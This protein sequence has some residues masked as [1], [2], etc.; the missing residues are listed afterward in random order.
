MKTMPSS[1]LATAGGF[2]AILLW[3]TT[4]AVSRSLSEQVGPVTAAAAVCSVGGVAAVASLLRCSRRRRQIL[5]LP[6]RYLVGCGA[7]FVGYMLLLYLA[8]GWARSRQ[9][10]LEVGLLNYLWP[11]WTL[12]LSLVLLGKK[13]NW[14]LFPGTLLALAGIFLVVTQ[15]E[16]VS[17][18]SFARHFASNPGAYSLAIAAAAAWA[19]Y[20]S[21]TSKWAG[22]QKEGG[23]AFFLPITAMVLFLICCFLDEPCEWNRRAIAESLFMGFATY[24]AYAL[25]DNAMRRGSVVMVV[26]ASYLTPL[27]S[28]IASCLYLA[29]MP[30]TRLWAGCAI[31]IF[32]SVLSWQSISNGVS[33]ESPHNHPDDLHRPT[34]DIP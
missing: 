32:G 17:W 8:I 11:T 31:L 34:Q 1:H 16:L 22:G 21:L 26:A 13:A 33:G 23:V 20:S 10:V 29:V 2:I 27:F 19:M 12:L 24:V 28:T 5:R 3:S 9:E 14:L 6:V 15:G 7:L 4:V 25:W 18:R 30:G